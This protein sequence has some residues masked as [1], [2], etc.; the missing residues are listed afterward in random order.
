MLFFDPLYLLFVAPAFL[1]ALLAQF[2]VKSAYRRYSRVR[3]SAGMTGAQAAQQVL[4]HAGIRDVRIERVSGF[5]SDHYDPRSRVLR[6]SPDNYDGRSVA[7]VGIAAHEAGHAIQHARNYSPLILRQTLA[8]LAMFG[9]NFAWILLF[10]GIFLQ[11][12]GLVYAGIGLFGAAVLFSLVTLPVEF[13]ASR[14]AK[15]L[16]P[17][18]GVI[19]RGPETRGVNAVLNAAALTYVAAAAMA[20]AQLLYFLVRAGLLGGSDD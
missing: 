14:R 10:I 2:W 11:F 18:M 20:I 16:L 19:E 8:P 17:A 6:L 7:A 1:L 9:S 12:A 5:L 3:A 13:D 4:A 15:Q